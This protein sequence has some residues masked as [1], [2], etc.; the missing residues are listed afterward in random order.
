FNNNRKPPVIDIHLA[1]VIRSGNFHHIDAHLVLPEFWSLNEA[2]PFVDL[3]EKLSIDDY[4]GDGEINFHIDPCYR[5]F[6]SH[7]LVEPC[8]VRERPFES[9]RPFTSEGLMTKAKHD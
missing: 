3:F 5:R 8:P 6:C 9:L 4:V 2:H 7:C 1:K